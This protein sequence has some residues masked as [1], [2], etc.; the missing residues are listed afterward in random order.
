MYNS[1][2]SGT[3][4]L[5]YP[6][7]IPLDSQLPRTAQSLFQMT[8]KFSL[9]ELMNFINI[10][11]LIGDQ[12]E[13][14][15]GI[16]GLPGFPATVT[17]AE[18]RNQIAKYLGVR[19]WGHQ[20]QLPEGFFLFVRTLYDTNIL[21]MLICYM[22]LQFGLEEPSEQGGWAIGEPI[23]RPRTEEQPLELLINSHWLPSPTH[24]PSSFIW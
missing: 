9:L 16:L 11:W 19:P 15:A 24:G 6:I 13:D 8:G 2:A 22:I 12:C 20:T 7:W 3:A 21:N 23:G 18:Q 10:L 1:A 5:R 14:V 17:V 4:R